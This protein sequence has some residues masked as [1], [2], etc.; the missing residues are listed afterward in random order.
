MNTNFFSQATALMPNFD[1]QFGITKKEDLF[2]V[3]ITLRPLDGNE[4]QVKSIGPIV[5][6]NATAEELDEHFFDKIKEPLEK[7]A[8]F[9]SDNIEEF[10]KNLDKAKEKAVKKKP[11]SK[12]TTTFSEKGKETKEEAEETDEE[13]NDSLTEETEEVTASKPKSKTAAKPEKKETPKPILDDKTELNADGYLKKG[14]DLYAKKDFEG[15]LK[16]YTSAFELEKSKDK[17]KLIQESISS[18]NVKIKAKKELFGEGEEETAEEAEE[19]DDFDP[20]DL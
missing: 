6:D 15:A 8:G 18:C 11:T 5:L 2:A 10:S 16:S 4:E 17:K 1:L 12:T 13:V 7:A 3:I 20:N 9:F 14:N 19:D